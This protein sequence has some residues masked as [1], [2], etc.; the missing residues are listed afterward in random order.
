MDGDKTTWRAYFLFP[1]KYDW[2]KKSQVLK[3]KNKIGWKNVSD[4]S[5]DANTRHHPFRRNKSIFSFHSKM[6]TFTN[7]L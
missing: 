1:G 2:K 5:G 7:E 3:K 4:F 6:P